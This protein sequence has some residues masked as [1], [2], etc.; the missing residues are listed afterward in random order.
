MQGPTADGLSMGAVRSDKGHSRVTW[1]S[2]ME[3]AGFVTV[4]LF[5]FLRSLAKKKG[6][7][8]PYEMTV[9]PGGST[10]AQ[11][12]M[13]LDL[14]RERI[15]AVFRNGRIQSLEEKVFA[16]DRIA[17]VPT[18]TPGPYRVLLGM[19]GASSASV[20]VANESVGKEDEQGPAAGDRGL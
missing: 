8:G 7:A 3:E 20:A 9:S 12:A 5:G 17:F 18:G 14:P 13:R 15:E 2:S 6:F 4:R 16:G 10:G 19:V 1:M 11:I